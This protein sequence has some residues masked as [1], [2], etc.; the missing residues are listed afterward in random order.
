MGG[1]DLD[2][3]IRLVQ[4]GFSIVYDPSVIVFHDD[5]DSLRELRGHAYR[6]G[7]GLTA[8]LTKHLVRGPDRFELLRAIPAGVRYLLDPG[9]R[10]NIQKA[11]DYPK[12]LKALEY[13]GMLLGPVAYAARLT[14]SRRHN[15]L[16]PQRSGPV[17]SVGGPGE[18]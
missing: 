13:C 16:S 11:S 8:M 2:L 9:S 14:G 4:N 12:M 18:P 10:K 6:Y 7:I 3:F 5:P 15:R 17:V 1:E